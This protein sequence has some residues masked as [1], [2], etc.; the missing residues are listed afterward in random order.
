MVSAGRFV[1][2]PLPAMDDAGPFETR[3]TGSP[4]TTVEH[5][6]FFGLSRSLHPVLTP[7]R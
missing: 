5:G 2:E 7:R 3:T 1:N 4:L 6:A